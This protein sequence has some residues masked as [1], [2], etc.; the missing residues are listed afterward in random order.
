MG[1]DELE[2]FEGLA[3]GFGPD[4]VEIE[5]FGKGLVGDHGPAEPEFSDLLKAFR[6]FTHGTQIPGQTH[7][8][9]DHRVRRDR[10]IPEARENRRANP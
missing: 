3:E 9:Q 10:P 5:L 6:A 7:L 8:A 2:G 1:L 4:Y